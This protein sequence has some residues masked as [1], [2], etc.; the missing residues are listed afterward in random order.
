[1]TSKS[2]RSDTLDG[3]PKPVQLD[4]AFGL[5]PVF[6]PEGAAADGYLYL[7]I[8]H[9][10]GHWAFPKGHAES[11]ETPLQSAKREFEEETGI[12]AYRVVAETEFVETYEIHKS[13]R[14]IHKTVTYFPAIAMTQT[15]A[16]QAAEI[17]DFVWLPYAAA[18]DRITF[19]A[20]RQVID[21]AHRF[22]QGL[23]LATAAFV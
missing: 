10:A 23:D 1:M 4:A 22:W 8:Q 19:P 13:K 11:D 20:N 14:T 18:R 15:T 16:V 2:N 3:T 9:L 21:D 6:V 5:V 17:N 7:L 12:T